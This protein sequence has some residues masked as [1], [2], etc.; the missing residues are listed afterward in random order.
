MY[1][2]HRSLH[3]REA[4]SSP[5]IL[6]NEYKLYGNYIEGDLEDATY[7]PSSKGGVDH[8]IYKVRVDGV[9][10]LFSTLFWN[11]VPREPLDGDLVMDVMSGK[12]GILSLIGENAMLS[13]WFGHVIQVNMEYVMTLLP[14][15]VKSQNNG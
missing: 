10:T 14:V 7:Y 4:G 6:W 3:E 1:I 13:P 9:S 12:T 8:A 2:W 11:I 15:N 5:Q